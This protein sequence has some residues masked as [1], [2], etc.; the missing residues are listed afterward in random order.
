MVRAVAS[1]SVGV[2][3]RGGRSI[4]GDRN[5]ERDVAPGRANGEGAGV[6]ALR[7]RFGRHPEALEVG[8]FVRFGGE[9]GLLRM[10]QDVVEA[11]KPS[12][13]DFG[14]SASAMAVIF[15]PEGAVEG[16]GV[17]VTDADRA[18]GAAAK[19]LSFVCPPGVHEG[20]YKTAGGLR[21]DAVASLVL[22]AGKDSGV[23]ARQ[24][25]MSHS[26]SRSFRSRWRTVFTRGASERLVGAGVV[27]C[28]CKEA[29]R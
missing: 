5:F 23:E 12:D 3:E 28:V 7:K 24:T 8:H 1:A 18:G 2:D 26:V 14:R 11:E 22:G 13:S 19:T 15:D 17:D 4:A 16:A 6:R 29:K 9:P 20:A 25:S 21:A 27:P 10:F